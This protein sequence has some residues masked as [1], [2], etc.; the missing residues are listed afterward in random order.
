M[1]CT[2]PHHHNIYMNKQN[3]FLVTITPC[4]FH[5]VL[6][7]P[8]TSSL[9]TTNNV[10]EKCDAI[11]TCQHQPFNRTHPNSR[12]R[13]GSAGLSVRSVDICT[14]AAWPVDAPHPILTTAKRTFIGRHHNFPV[15]EPAR[16]ANHH[17]ARHPSSSLV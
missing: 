15:V 11:G 17:V 2:Q 10:R 13:I 5:C 4:L 16:I 8:P 12:A 6:S 9:V 14:G 3:N 7:H 1:I